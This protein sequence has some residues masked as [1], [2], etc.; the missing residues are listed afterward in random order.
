[1]I[2]QNLAKGLMT[3]GLCPAVRGED[4]DWHFCGIW[5]KNCWEWTATLLAC[6]H[7]DMTT[8]G[9]YD[10]MSAEQVDFILKQTEM[11][12]IV[13]TSDYAQKLIDMKKQGMAQFVGALVVC[14]GVSDGLRSEATSQQILTYSF[15]QVMEEGAKSESA[16]AYNEPTKDSVYIFSYTSG[17]TG[18]SK[19][20]KLSHEMI[21]A[22]AVCIN[23]RIAF[24]PGE[25]LI[26]YLPY[27]HSFEQGLFGFSL[28]NGLRIGFYTGDPLRLVEDVG[29]LKPDMF[30]SVP[31]LYNRIYAK[32]KAGLDAATGC[33]KWLAGKAVA[34]KTA[35]YERDG[36][37]THGCW[38]KLV[39]KKMKALLGGRVRVMVT[40]SAPI[41]KAVIDF[42]KISFCCPIVEGYGLTESSG[43]ACISDVAD[44]LTGHVGGP[45]ESV[46]FRLMDLPE[47]SYLSADKPYPRGEVQMYGPLIFK[48]YYKRPDK[49]A[50]AFTDD[51]WFR[52]G[53]VAMLYPNGTLKIIDRSKNIFKLSQGEYI[54]PEKIEGILSLS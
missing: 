37:V 47:M 23:A 48:G 1:M 31:R 39:F 51:G 17:T 28:V 53:D 11:K 3:L 26:S 36:S 13:C 7:Y 46:K 2:A 14:D 41:D 21:L 16:P 5:A 9:F 4:R 43:G 34:S 29:V 33:K 42:L 45:L 22:S 44:P 38:D 54:A 25:T 35:N 6:M 12:T 24:T 19:G 40:G 20:V 32:L 18:D 15:D 8:V 49:T 52:T 10:A 27:T 50:E 30:P